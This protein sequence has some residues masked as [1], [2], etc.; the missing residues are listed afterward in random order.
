MNP[1]KTNAKR[2]YSDFLNNQRPTEDLNITDT[3]R[4][5]A[6]DD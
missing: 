4:K 2:Q 5:Q 3:G 1:V 6:E